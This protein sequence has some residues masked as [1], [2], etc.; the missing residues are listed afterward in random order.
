MKCGNKIAVLS[1]SKCNSLL[2]ASDK[3]C[4][5]YG[6]PVKTIAENQTTTSLASGEITIIRLL[7]QKQRICIFAR[8]VFINE[9]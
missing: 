9:K 3:F 7:K 1:C 5:K 8:P 2:K 4:S 6:T